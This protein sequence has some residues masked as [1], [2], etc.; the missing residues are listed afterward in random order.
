VKVLPRAFAENPERL[1]RFEREARALAS[2]NHPNIGAIYGFEEVDGERALIL[3]LVEG[4]SLADRLSAGALPVPEAVRIAQQIALAL[5]AAHEKGIL[6]RDLKPANIRITP[7]GTVKVLDSLAW[8]SHF[9]KTT[10]KRTA[11]G[12]LRQPAKASF[13]EQSHTVSGTGAGKSGR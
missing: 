1:H 2:F 7:D 9:L 4:Q 10:R 13:L 6:H 3:E 11:Q 5:E 8:R 12:P